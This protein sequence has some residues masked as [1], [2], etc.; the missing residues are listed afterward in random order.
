MILVLLMFIGACA[1][2]TGGGLNLAI[3]DFSKA[4]PKQL[5]LVIH[6]R[7]SR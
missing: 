1:G 2:S 4:I 3:A 5:S 7:E 6:P